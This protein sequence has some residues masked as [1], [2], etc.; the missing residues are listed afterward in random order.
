MQN[1]LN[2]YYNKGDIEAGIDEAGRGPLIGPVY[3]AAVILDPDMELHEWLNDS[4]KMS[5]KRREIVREFVEENAVMYA[6]ASEDEKVI[7][8]VNILNA[9]YSAMHRTLDNLGI[10]PDHIIIDGNRFIP[11]ITENGEYIPYTCIIGGDSKYASICAASVLAKENHDDYIKSLCEQYP[12]LDDRYG[13]LSNMGY[14]A[15]KHM[16][17][18]RKYG[19]SRFHRKS[20]RPCK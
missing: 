13:L 15:Q 6:V 1:N 9:T 20:F 8:K 4:K 7:D 14:G 19:V 18:I 2:K 5:R 3:A 17:G 16:D 12:E 10:E 11:Y